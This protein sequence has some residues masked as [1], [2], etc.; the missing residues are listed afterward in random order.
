MQ[1]LGEFF[2]V[3]T[4]HIPHPLTTDEAREIV[5]AISILPVQEIDL[6]MMYYWLGVAH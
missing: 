4:R 5:S 3:V 1:V 6:A 2:N